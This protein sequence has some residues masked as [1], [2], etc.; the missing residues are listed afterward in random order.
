MENKSYIQSAIYPNHRTYFLKMVRLYGID[1]NEN[2]TLLHE[3]YIITQYNNEDS[4]FTSGYKAYQFFSDRF[5][6]NFYLTEYKKDV[7]SGKLHRRYA[8]DFQ[9]N[10]NR[11]EITD[12]TTFDEVAL[13]MIKQMFG[14]TSETNYVSTYYQVKMLDVL[15]EEP[16]TDIEYEYKVITEAY[17]KIDKI[18][19]GVA[20]FPQ[21]FI[22]KGLELGLDEYGEGIVLI[23][24]L[25]HGEHEGIHKR[26]YPKMD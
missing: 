19:D 22:Q 24:E 1:I 15:S 18:N 7:E 16:I 25:F 17:G 10:A 8:S 2:S 20:M 6:H 4:Y 3:E 9:E 14:I 11:F 5:Y 21:T 12:M 13:P 26:F 23:K